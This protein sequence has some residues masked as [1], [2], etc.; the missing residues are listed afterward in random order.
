M[1]DTTYFLMDHYM[2]V[3]SQIQCLMVLE[4][5]IMKTKKCNTQENGEM[6]FLKVLDNKYMEMVMSMMETFLM[7]NGMEKE[8]TNG[9]MEEFM[10]DSL[11]MALCMEMEFYIIV[12]IRWF[13]EVNLLRIE[14]M[15]KE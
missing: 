11:G 13:I 8:S 4:H 14:R 12:E 6:E 5:F 1:K 15:D 9:L 7:E 3:I 10:K 2:R